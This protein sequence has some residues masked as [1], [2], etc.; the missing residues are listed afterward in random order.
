MSSPILEMLKAQGVP[1][2]EWARAWLSLNYFGEIPSEIDGETLYSVVPDEIREE[3][4]LYFEKPVT[5]SEQ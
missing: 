1:R 2:S 3:V 4:E 5:G